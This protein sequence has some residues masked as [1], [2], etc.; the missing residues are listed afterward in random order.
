MT[1]VGDI[2]A[3]ECWDEI[4]NQRVASYKTMYNL[5]LLPIE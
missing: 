2:T 1:T 5:I 4:L 3:N